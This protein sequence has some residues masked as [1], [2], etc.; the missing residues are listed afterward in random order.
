MHYGKVSLIALSAFAAVCIM[1]PGLAAPAWSQSGSEPADQI[2]RPIDASQRVQTNGV[3]PLAV[4]QDDQGRVDPARVFH[5]MVLLLQGSDAEEQALQQMLAAQQDPSSAEY[6]Q[7]LT[8]A[9]FGRRFGP[10]Q[11]DLAALTGWLKGQG[12]MVEPAPSGRRYLI[13]SGSSGQVEAAFQTQM[14]RYAVGGVSYLANATPASVPRALAGVVKGVAS[15]TSF[16]P[17]LPQSWPANVK[18]FQIQTGVAATGPAD[19]A[20]IYNSAPLNKAGVQGQGESVALIEESNIVL[21]DLTDFRTVTGLPAATVNVIV[22]GPDPGPLYYDGEEFEAIADT[23]YAGAMA[24]QATLNVV[25]TAS[26]DLTQGILLSMFY[27]VDN[28]VSPV[29]SLSYGG[30]ET[31]NDAYYASVPKAFAAAYEQGATEGIS[32]FVSTG[33]YGGDAC[34]GLGLAAGYGVNAIGD[35]PWNVS[36][37]G[38]EFIMPDPNTY[39]PP[40]SYTATGYIP[41]RTWNDYENPLDGRP[42]SGSGGVSINFTKPAW[43]SGPGVPADG[44]RDVPDVSLLAGDNLYY[45]TCEADIGYDCAK[46]EGGGVIGTSLGSP[47]W[48]AIQALVNQKNSL[49]GGA[50]NPNPTYYRL[51]AGAKSPFHDITVGDTKVPDFGSTLVGYVAT[52][53]FDLATGLGSVDVNALATAWLPP[54]GSGKA[55]VSLTTN[56]QSITHGGSLTATVSM[57]SNGSPAPTGDVVLMAGSQGAAQVTLASGTASFAFG[58]TSGVTLP[59]GSYNLTAHYAGDANFAPADSS[60]VAL[61]IDPEATSTQAFVPGVYTYGQ[62]L[63]LSAEAFGAVSEQTVP[64]TYTFIGN[65]K[66]LGTAAVAMTGD[67]F[68]SNIAGLTAN[69]T[70]S[71]AKSLPAG[72]YSVIA[73]SPA[74]SASFL[75]SASSA[76]T[77]TVAKAP[78]LVSLTPDHTTP[79]LNSTVN[80]LATVNNIEGYL[81]PITGTVDFFD[82]NTKI[83]SG[84]LAAKADLLGA[85]DATVAARF[86]T[87]GLHTLV[88]RYEG[89]NND[90]VNS[91]GLV[92]ITVNSKSSSSITPYGPTF[93]LAQTAT[94]ITAFVTGDANNATPTGT[95]TFTDASAN[96]GVGAAIGTAPVGTN[97]MVTFSANSLA[98]GHHYIFATYGGDANYLGSTSQSFP[99]LV[100]DFTLKASPATASATAGQSTAAITITYSGTTDF[101]KPLTGSPYASSGVTLACS[102]LPTGTGCDF[103]STNIVPTA[104]A[105]GTTTGTTT[106]TISTEGPTLQTGMTRRPGGA[107]PAAFAGLLALGLPLVFRRRRWLASLLG[108]ALL[109]FA[110]GLNGCSSVTTKSGYQITNPGTPAGSSTV[111]VTATVN[112]GTAGTL[113]HTATITLTVAAAGQ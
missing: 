88:A 97:G 44:Q 99:I 106:L 111:T 41:E 54:T 42:I 20:A 66:T 15:L 87:P 57:T 38:T 107:L 58:S 72:T 6:H 65:G 55:S 105:D 14:H 26:T 73:D 13:F 110:A 62:G 71:G 36:V 74:A 22:N 93:G 80:L 63:T 64:G 35:S 79:P 52:P 37:G 5:R 34:E 109:A 19:L 90:L 4:P 49:P 53:G 24:P 46:G 95:V 92:N 78:V 25:V 101:S 69:L 32:Q 12:F 61:T 108:L 30:C 83:G 39:F 113:S 43:Q 45:L 3:H 40:P 23:E 11:N 21:E 56:A 96:Q 1:T 86:T 85:F 81:A 10:S 9:E 103:T 70:L 17:M 2:V 94:Q 47:N 84:T 77:L 76:V 28:M 50:G 7:W 68:A 112:G 59:G 8:P 27:A 48:A 31:L 75:A 91:S 16:H 100:G 67:R 102:G 18:E 82:G 89:D 51:A 60:A 104:N 98:A 29:T 33:D